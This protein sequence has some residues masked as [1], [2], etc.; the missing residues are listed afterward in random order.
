MKTDIQISTGQFE[1]IMQS[2]DVELTP[3]Q[4]V[5]AYHTLRA[6]Y[7]PKTGIS[8]KEF[9]QSLDL[10]LTE[11]TGN[12]EQYLAMSPSQQAVFQ[13]IKKSLARIKAHDGR[14]HLKAIAKEE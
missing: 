5:E 14:E 9:N 6:A 4:A 8:T 7:S 10:Y 11:E 3:E 12:T 2:Y 13:E 1:Y